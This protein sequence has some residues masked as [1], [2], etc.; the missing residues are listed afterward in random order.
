[1]SQ[2]LTQQQE[3]YS[4]GFHVTEKY[5]FKSERGL[6]KKIFEQISEM[7]SEPGWMR[8]AKRQPLGRNRMHEQCDN[9]VVPA[10]DEWTC[11]RSDACFFLLP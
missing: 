7:K 6:S 1:M 9:A 5:A 10:L 8:Q 4:P 11:C 2:I 3:A